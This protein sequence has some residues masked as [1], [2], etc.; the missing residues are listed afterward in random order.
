MSTNAGRA[1]A[2]VPPGA[3]IESRRTGPDS[4]GAD[5]DEL[6]SRRD[7]LEAAEVGEAEVGEDELGAADV[8]AD[9]VGADE[10][11]ESD[12]GEV[13][14]VEGDGASVRG[15]SAEDPSR[16]EGAAGDEPEDDPSAEREADE[17][18]VSGEDDTPEIDCVLPD[19]GVTAVPPA[20]PP[21]TV[22][23]ISTPSARD[24]VRHAADPFTSMSRSPLSLRPHR[25]GR[26]PCL[27]HT[28][29]G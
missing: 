19:V 29:D 14:E 11:E 20:Q 28:I 7:E 15:V 4:P 18:D 5:T 23:T 22:A 12:G 1:P 8:G 3:G 10:V 6:V 16:V 27:R 25:A 21:S 9:E 26:C 2:R 13:D 17:P 24:A